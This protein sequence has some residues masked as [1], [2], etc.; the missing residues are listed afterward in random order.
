MKPFAILSLWLCLSLFYA[1][2]Q[3]TPIQ[4]AEEMENT[5]ES[6]P[7]S[8]AVS[9]FFHAWMADVVNGLSSDE[10]RYFAQSWMRDTAR[11][12]IDSALKNKT[13]SDAIGKETLVWGPALV[14]S[15]EKGRPYPY[16]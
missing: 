16:T 11:T 2:E 15:E 9:H 8:E 5:S 13:I 14:L 10:T 7:S 6:G 3:S 12:R 1:C 4:E